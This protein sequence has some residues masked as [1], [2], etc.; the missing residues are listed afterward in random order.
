MVEEVEAQ[1][2]AKAQ[3][4]KSAS[5]DEAAK[6]ASSAARIALPLLCLGLVGPP[7]PGLPAPAPSLVCVYLAACHAHPACPRADAGRA[8]PALAPCVLPSAP[9]APPC[10]AEGGP[11]PA[12]QA[13]AAAGSLVVHSQMPAAG[14]AP[15]P[16]TAAAQ[17]AQARSSHA[18]V[19][20]LA[21]KWPRPEWHAPWKLYRV[22]SGH[23]GWVRSIAFEPGNEWFATGS[24][25]R[26]IKVWETATGK[27]KLTLTGHIE[28]IRSLVVSQRHPYMFSA[29]DDNQ[30]KCW[31]LETNKVVRHYHGH[32][33]G[34]YCMALHPTV[35]VLMTGGRD[36]VCRVWDIRTRKQVHVLEGHNNTVCSVVSQAHDPQVI[37]GSHDSTIKTW[38]LVAGK[39]STT[40]TFHKKSVRAMALHPTENCFASAS[41]DNIKKFKLPEGTFMHNM[42]EQQKCIVN[43]MAI[44]EDNVMA[45]CGDNGTTWFW[46]WTSGHCYQKEM[47]IVQ[48]GS[49]DAEAGIFACSFDQTGTRFV[50]CEADKTIKMYK[51]DLSATKESHPGL[52][53]KPPTDMRRF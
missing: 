48:P 22:I 19:K 1:E 28:Q 47:A 29:G 30:V 2:K 36:S 8:L 15:P 34:V 10:V 42:L 6:G 12:Y 5:A 7:C 52:E 17:A 49:L 23:L 38:D 43:C 45:T 44:N 18:L 16:R 9:P 20:R 11:A 32:L 50:T 40:L 31:D 4:K 33:S 21:H 46:D 26:T 53:F 39:C 3:D 13:S 51:P 24:A 41:A 25:D 27:L 14:G 37:T 35:D